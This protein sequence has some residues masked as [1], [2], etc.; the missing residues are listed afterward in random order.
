VS[1]CFGLG[2]DGVYRCHSFD[3]FT[4]LQHGFGTRNAHPNSAI[5]LRQVHSDQVVV[6]R[7][8]GD[9]EREGDALITDQIGT[10]IG[11]RTADCVS[12]LLLDPAHRAVAAVHAGWRGTAARIVVRTLQRMR[13]E[14]RSNSMDVYAALGPCIRACCYEVGP[15]VAA[16][17]EHSLEVQLAADGK[18]KLDL[19]QANRRQLETAGVPSADFRFRPMHRGPAGGILLLSARA[20]AFR[21]H[22]GFYLPAR[23]GH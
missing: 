16:H 13:A 11:I 18:Y 12:M 8:L 1:A 21:P 5:T 19:A 6:A 23:I 22:A 7:G 3:Q 9:R 10:T 14:F 15:E 17:F 4:W 2:A 20:A